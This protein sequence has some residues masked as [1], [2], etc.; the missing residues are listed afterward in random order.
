M[1]DINLLRPLI[2]QEQETAKSRGRLS[3]YITFTIILIIFISGVIFGVKFYFLYQSRALDSQITNLK[4]DTAEVKSIEDNINNFNNVITQLKELDKNKFVWS[5]V[6][7]NI[8]KSTPADI[9]LNQVSLTSATASAAAS[10]QKSSTAAA[11][12]ATSKLKITGVTKSRR[13]I[14]LF[15]DKLQKI[16][17]NFTTV[18]IISSKKTE[19]TANQSA[20]GET[21]TTSAEEKIDFEINISLK[22]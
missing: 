18:D 15:A 7:D 9:K 11:P 1:H 2:E 21:A 20:G 17:G 13:A 5:T 4:K 22:V 3:F 6:Y 16:G 8:A 14:A 12:A 10:S 19:A